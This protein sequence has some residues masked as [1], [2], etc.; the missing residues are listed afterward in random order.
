MTKKV[1]RTA[2]GKIVDLGALLLQNEN[3]RAVGNMRVNARG[4]VLD[5]NNRSVASRNQQVNR[6]YNRQVTNVSDSQVPT[7]RRH[8]REMAQADVLPEETTAPVIE[9]VFQEPV[10]EAPAPVET[11]GLPEGGLAAAI[12]KARQIKQ[13]PLKTPRQQA[14]EKSGVNKI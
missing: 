9:E 1:Y 13:E 12:A 7:S 10:I 2:Q 11:S 14:Q 3:T 6:Q 4:D 8:A 5:S